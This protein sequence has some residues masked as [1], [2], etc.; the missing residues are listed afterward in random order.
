MDNRPAVKKN[1]WVVVGKPQSGNVVS[2]LVLG[3]YS[4][5]IDVGYYQNRAKAI[6]EEVVWVGDHWEFKYSG[7]NGSYLRGSEEAAV[8][9]GPPPRS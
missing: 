4:D 8:K 1:E 5:Y 3:V 7:P 6:K 9:R 2:G